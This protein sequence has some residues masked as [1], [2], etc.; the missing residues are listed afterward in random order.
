MNRHMHRT[1]EVQREVRNH[2]LVAILRDLSHPVASRNTRGLQL[3]PQQAG[4]IP[5]FPPSPPMKLATTYEAECALILACGNRAS[6]MFCN[7][8]LVDPNHSVMI[9]H[10]AR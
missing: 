1:D 3:R 4:S 6:E 10:N 5:H 9:V 7:R 2:P 8:G